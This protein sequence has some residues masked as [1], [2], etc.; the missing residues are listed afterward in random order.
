MRRY[1]FAGLSIALLHVPYSVMAQNQTGTVIEREAAANVLSAPRSS[2]VSPML[3]MLKE[4]HQLNQIPAEKRSKQ[5]V[6]STRTQVQGPSIKNGMVA[7]EAMSR[8]DDAALR[9]QLTATGAKNVRTV[10]NMTLAKIA[11]ENI[12]KLDQLTAARFVR[13]SGAK[14]TN[15][16]RVTSQGDAA[17]RSDI[18]R[19]Q[20]SVNGDGATVGIISDSWN[21]DGREQEGID[22]GEIPGKG[23][24]NGFTKKVDVLKDED[25]DG[26]DEGRGMGEIVHDV[27]PGAKLSFYG[28]DSFADHAE[29]IR[30][31]VKKAKSTV[32]VDDL[33]WATESWYQPGPIDRAIRD[34]GLES[35]AVV[36]SSAGNE[37]RSSLEGTF[38][39]T[40]AKDLLSEGSSVG[41]WQLHDFGGGNVTTPIT[42]RAGASVRIVLQWDEPFASASENGNGSQSDLDLILFQESQGVNILTAPLERNVGNDA[43]EFT[44]LTLDT[45]A[46][47]DVAETYH[48]GVARS[49]T[50]T[51]TPRGFKILLVDR[52]VQQVEVNRTEQF[53]KSTIL[54]HASSPWGIASCAVRYNQVNDGTN[55]VPEAFSSVAGFLRTRDDN[56]NLL[57]SQS[58]PLKPDVCSP[59][60][61]NTSF[62]PPG[63]DLEGDGFPNFFGTSASAPHLAGVVALMQQSAGFNLPAF[64]VPSILRDTA[65]DMD[66]P[67]TSQFDTGYDRKTG[68][69]FLFADRAIEVAQQFRE[70]KS[71]NKNKKDKKDKK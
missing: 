34:V 46:G 33:T 43:V 67:S 28:P 3:K 66:D 15:I 22:A 12:D 26:T 49:T 38:T 27:A 19:T 64:G 11:P 23:N 16:G 7:I 45:D 21:I 50:T 5:Q 47:A 8:G 37:E 25:E 65:V 36:L 29:G 55:A 53:N 17:Q 39:P 62:F 18:A 2:V 60:G 32:V 44:S 42:L 20:F 41:Q 35:N 1:L 31:L 68:Y 4:Q 61:G 52:G 56:G 9:T 24:P 13:A 69:G 63:S 30:E 40:A 14:D 71:Q 58:D 51:G 6:R 57:Q 10:G 48:I 70:E 59:N 54:G